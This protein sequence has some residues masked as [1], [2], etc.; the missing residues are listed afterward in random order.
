MLVTCTTC[1]GSPCHPLRYQQSSVF[2]SA[3]NS[4]VMYQGS[5][6]TWQPGRPDEAGHLRQRLYEPN[7]R[8]Q[9]DGRLLQLLAADRSRPAAGGGNRSLPEVTRALHGAAKVD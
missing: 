8:Q 5:V 6:P 7:A 2:N 4:E 9:L 3:V 1:N